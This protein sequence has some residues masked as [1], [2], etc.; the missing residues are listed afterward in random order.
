MSFRRACGESDDGGWRWAA[1]LVGLALVRGLLYA[2]LIPPWQAPDEPWHFRQ[3]WR[4]ARGGLQRALERESL[5]SFERERMASLYEWRFGEFFRPLPD[6]MPESPPWE[7]DAPFSLSYVW[8]ALWIWPVR[9]ED[10]VTQLYMARLGNVVLSAFIAWVAW[11]VFTL[12]APPGPLRAAMGMLVVFLPQHTFINSSVTDGTL[13]ELAGTAA[14]YGWAKAFRNRLGVR[15]LFTILLGLGVAIWSKRTALFLMPMTLILLVGYLFWGLFARRQRW[16]QRAA[17]L[18][19]AA[20]GISLLG[21][22]AWHSPVIRVAFGWLESDGSWGPPA[23][24]LDAQLLLTFDSFWAHFGWLRVPLSDRWSGA[25]LLLCLLAAIGWM[26]WGWRSV[27]LGFPRWAVGMM[28]GYFLTG[29]GAFIGFLSRHPAY[30]QGRYLFPLVVPF[31]FLFVG[32]LALL[33]SPARARMVALG[34]CFLV[35]LLDNVSIFWYIIPF[36]WR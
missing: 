7:G 30:A 13:A 36:F 20:V 6:R 27:V 5:Q 10:I 34:V 29:L 3:A 17:A 8:L 18:A 32:G 26:G 11:R 35:I 12:I 9:H 19:V 1:L 16:R 33:A 23:D 15:E 22:T 24:H 21:W 28:G 14:F 25:L 31:S 4:I 2:A